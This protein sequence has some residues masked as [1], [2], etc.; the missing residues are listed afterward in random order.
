VN[1]SFP[2]LNCRLRKNEISV[3]RIRP[4]KAQLAQMFL[5][6][7]FFVRYAFFLFRL[8][9]RLWCTSSTRVCCAC[10]SFSSDG[11]PFLR[12]FFLQRSVGLSASSPR[13]M[14]PILTGS[15]QIKTGSLCR[16]I[17][18]GVERVKKF[19][20]VTFSMELKKFWLIR[21]KI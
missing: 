2:Y 8:F 21:K 19:E 7:Q 14:N 18:W 13:K 4:L 12:T 10:A 15:R 9:S 20:D 1:P 6:R 5:S 16:Q 11:A 3:F 17:V